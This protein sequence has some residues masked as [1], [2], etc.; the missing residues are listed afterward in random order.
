MIRHRRFDLIQIPDVLL[1]FIRQD[2]IIKRGRITHNKKAFLVSLS[3]QDYSSYRLHIGAN[4]SI[5]YDLIFANLFNLFGQQRPRL[6]SNI[7]SSP[8]MLSDM[9]D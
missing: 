4:S 1:Q 7:I 2:E 6:S 8:L 3:E 5:A 9:V